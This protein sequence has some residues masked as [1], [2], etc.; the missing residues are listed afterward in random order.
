GHLYRWNLISNSLDQAVT[1]GSGIGQPYVPTVIGNDGT[2]FTLNGGT[3]F[4][5]GPRPGVDI[6]ISSSSPDLR[7]NLVGSPITFQAIVTGTT[8]TPTGTVTFTDR[9]YDGATAINTTLAANVPLDGNGRA[10]VTTSSLTAGGSVFGN[11]FITASYNGDASHSTTAVTMMQKVH[12]AASVTSLLSSINPANSDNQITF[13]ASVAAVS[14][15][16]GNPTGMV[17]FRDG[18]TVIGQVPLDSAGTASL[19]RSNL[20]VGSHTISATY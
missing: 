10:S 8:P 1:L 2:V 11:H 20:L 17:T 13:T 9:T 6:T 14:P 15:S 4:A 3:M 12:A 7:T 19:T 16:T 18:T 5:L